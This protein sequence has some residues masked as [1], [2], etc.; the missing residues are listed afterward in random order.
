MAKLFIKDFVPDEVVTTTLLVRKKELPKKKT[1]EPYLK[2]ILTDKTGTITAMMW[3]NPEEAATGFSEEDFVRVKGQVSL[4]NN[5]L[6]L[7]LHKIERIPEEE[8]DPLDYLPTT[9]YDIEEMYG[10][11]LSM[12]KEI[13]NPHLSKLLSLIFSDD[14]F[15]SRFKI[16]PAAKS[17]HHAYL[18]GLLEHTLSVVRL[19]LAVSPLYPMID[20]DLLLTGAVLH[21][22]GKVREMRIGSDFNYTDEGRLLGHLMIELLEI[23]RLIANLPDFPEELALQLKH[24]LISHHG[25]L[26]FGSP[27]R[28]KTL[29][30]LILYYLDDLDSKLNAMLGAI[31]DTALTGDWSGYNRLLERYIYRKRP[32]EKRG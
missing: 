8:I 15:V 23:E 32:N 7:V 18:G 24:I 20:R 6:Q 12:I 9:S 4:Y 3:N 11:L 22:L 31:N 1:G 13:K 17:M 26:E 25:N 29:E 5:R 16:A 14:E 27:K 28:P 21:D 19:A 10:E 30:A 2:V